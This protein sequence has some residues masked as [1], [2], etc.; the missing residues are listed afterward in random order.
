MSKKLT[1]MDYARKF[2]DEGFKHSLNSKTKVPYI[3][4]AVRVLKAYADQQ[5]ESLQA[6]NER[7][8]NQ[9]KTLREQA[10]LIDKG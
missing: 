9:V 5:T 7:L 2:Y 8:K 6:E 1:A 4:G 10:R 3:D